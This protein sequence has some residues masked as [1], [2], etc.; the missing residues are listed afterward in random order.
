MKYSIIALAF[1]SIVSASETQRVASMVEDISKLRDDYA[2]CKSELESQS[3]IP[4]TT[5]TCRVKASELKNFKELLK[6]EQ[7]QNSILRKKIEL[8]EKEN[9]KSILE[10]QKILELEKTVQDQSKLLEMQENK[11]NSLN[12]ALL[13]KTKE[14][15]SNSSQNDIKNSLV[16]KEKNL[17]SKLVVKESSNKKDAG[18]EKAYATK[19]MTLFLKVDSSLYDAING[20]KVAEWKKD[21]P[22]TS[23]QRS[24]S[25]VKV[26]G[27]F[28]G[29]T[30][31]K[32][33]EELWVEV[34]NV[35]EKESTD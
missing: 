8:S 27:Y 31:K 28:V 5:S 16:C 34:V 4:Q 13:V 12:S 25:W 26:T 24:E 7:E 21:D 14:K 9:T 22:F 19:A 18:D 6:K 23:N 1:I 29:R 32:A 3:I 2:T 30:W 17:F 15:E 11:I 20:K 33:N 10:K 35:N